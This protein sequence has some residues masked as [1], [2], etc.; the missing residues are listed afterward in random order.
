MKNAALESEHDGAD[1]MPVGRM[2]VLVSGRTERFLTRIGDHD[3]DLDLPG[4]DTTR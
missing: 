4:S 3:D 2:P 1:D